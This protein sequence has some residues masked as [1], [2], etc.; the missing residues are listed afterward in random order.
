MEEQEKNE[1]VVEENGGQT[2]NPESLSEEKIV[3]APAKS[4]KLNKKKKV[5]LGCFGA[6]ILFLLVSVAII[7]YILSAVFDDIQPAQAVR[8]PDALDLQSVT[9]KLFATFGV[10]I[11]DDTADTHLD[12]D[13]FDFGKV[14]AREV[15][16]AG[17]LF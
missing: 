6:V 17:H 3:E 12:F 7:L 14:F 5:L 8:V 9:E 4:G 2:Q 15:E 16:C 13:D 11:G 10:S 1:R